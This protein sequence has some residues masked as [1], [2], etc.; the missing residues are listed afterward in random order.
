VLAT[1]RLKRCGI[2]LV[3]CFKGS[4]DDVLQDR[5]SGRTIKLTEEGRHDKSILVMSTQKIPKF[6]VTNCFR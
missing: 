2:R 1:Q 5:V 4:D 6:Q 3:G